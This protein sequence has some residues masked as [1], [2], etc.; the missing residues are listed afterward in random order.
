MFPAV[1]IIDMKKKVYKYVYCGKIK[2]K[3]LDALNIENERAVLYVIHV[4][5]LLIYIF[6]FFSVSYRER[7]CV[8]MCVRE[9]QGEW[10]REREIYSG[11]ATGTL[12]RLVR[13]S[14]RVY[15]IRITAGVRGKRWFRWQVNFFCCPVLNSVKKYKMRCGLEVRNLLVRS[16]LPF[17]HC[18]Y[19]DT[20]PPSPLS[21]SLSLPLVP[22]PSFLQHYVP[23]MPCTTR[24]RLLITHFY[25]HNPTRSRARTH[26]YNHTSF[27]FYCY[28]KPAL[29]T[30]VP[31]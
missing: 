22:P 23:G 8:C 5:C 11:K 28:R 21:L 12:G 15:C 7:E 9:R 4:I 2:S 6:S 3:D 24:Q 19:F 14:S 10:E 16:A 26:T 31:E 29:P 27:F 17:L 20:L 1:V 25:S 13:Q 30:V 18:F